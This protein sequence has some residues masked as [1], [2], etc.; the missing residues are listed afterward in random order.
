MALV[1]GPELGRLQ[2]R[3]CVAVR[4]LEY[5][6]VRRVGSVRLPLYTCYG[7]R[8]RL[9]ST[10]VCSYCSGPPA[11]SGFPV[12]YHMASGMDRHP[13]ILHVFFI[14]GPPAVSGFPSTRN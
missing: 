8:H 9:A 1:L 7:L 13:F 12:V 3:I 4:A 5:L 11:Q 10:C 14:T 2:D 6:V